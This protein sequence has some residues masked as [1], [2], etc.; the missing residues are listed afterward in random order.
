MKK[1]GTILLLLVVL[2]ACN[3]VEKDTYKVTV[4]VDGVEDGKQV[5][6]QKPVDGQR[7]EVI[8]TMEVKEGKF[9]FTGKAESPQLHYLFFEGVRGVLPIILE[10]GDIQVTAYKD[11]LNFSKIEGSPSNEDFTAFIQG[12]KTIR[13]KMSDIQ[14][15]GMEAQQSGDTITMNTLKETFEEAQEEARNYENDFVDTHK[16]SYI[17]LLVIQQMMRTKSKTSEEVGVLFN[18]LSED[19]KNT[20]LGKTISEELGKAN[21]LS[22]G[23]VAPDFSGPTPDGETVSLKGSLGK[24]T[25]LDFWAAWCKPCRAENPNLVKLYAEY[26]D[27]GLNVVGVSLD[28]KAEDWKKAIED[29]NFPWTHISNLKFWQDPIAQEYNIRSIPATFILDENGKIIA[30]DLRGEALNEKIASLLN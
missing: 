20:E 21:K 5:Y 25:V 12:S 14:K 13:D 23:A 17:S 16:E 8:D 1:I 27:K 15:K 19:I 3:K 30:K 11:S 9:E 6:L 2:V 29:D 7:P 10:E 26:H 28:R 4:S 22:V 24:V 18:D